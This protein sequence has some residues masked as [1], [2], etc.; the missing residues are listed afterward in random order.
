MNSKMQ[1]APPFARLDRLLGVQA[2]GSDD[3]ELARLE[4]PHRARRR[5]GR[6]R[7]PRRPARSRLELAQRE[8][9]D[10]V[11]VAEPDQL[12]LGEEHGREGALDASHRRRDRLLERPL[13]VGDERRDHL[14]VGGGREAHAPWR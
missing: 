4:L 14:R 10:P 12:P 5:A 13:V 1:S 3:D 2:I 8:R 9:P 6:T 7:T 11:R